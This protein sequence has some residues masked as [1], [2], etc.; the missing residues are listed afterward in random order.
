MRLE[1][2]VERLNGE[3]AGIAKLE[4]VRWERAFYK[5]TDTFQAQIPEAAQCD[6]VVAIFRHRL[7]TELPSG[8]PPMP[9]GE[10]YPSGTAYEILTALEVS[11]REGLPDVYVFRYPEPPTVTLDAE[12]ANALVTTQWE[13]LKAFFATWFLSASG[14]FTAA[15]HD[16]RSTDQF[17]TQIEALLR[18]WLEDKILE[19][20]AVVWPIATKG[21]PFRG[22]AAFAA[23]HAPVFFGRGRDTTKAVDA[24]KDAANRDTPFLLV[25]GPSGSG[26]S[27][28]ALAGISP[29]LTTPGVVPTV[30]IW[31]VATMRPGEAPGDPVRALAERLF[32]G[33][34]DI[35]EAEIGRPIALPEL[36]LSDFETP[37][38]LAGLLSHA[39]DTSV[40]PIVSA[41][42]RV[43]QEER[44]SGGYDRPLRADLL[45]VV[46][47][48][49]D[50]FAGDLPEDARRSFIDIL[51]RLVATGRVWVV[52]TLRANLYEDYL[53]LPE[54]LALKSSGAAY[55]LTPPGPA[56]LADI[57]HEPATAAGLV[58]ESDPETG[59]RLDERLLREADRPDMLPLLQFALAQLFDLRDP[60]DGETRLTYAAYESIGGIDGAIDQ[61]AENALRPLGKE[62]KDAL[63]KLLRMLVQQ[64]QGNVAVGPGGDSYRSVSLA[65]LE[66]APSVKHLAD[67]LVTARI[68]VLS[69]EASGGAVRVVHQRVLQSWQRAREAVQ[70]NADF[71][72]VRSDLRAQLGRWTESGGHTSTLVA[73]G[74][75]L[76]EARDLVRRFGDELKPDLVHFTNASRWRQLFFTINI[77]ALPLVVALVIVEIF[78]ELIKLETDGAIR[79]MGLFTLAV[80][81]PVSA[82]I[83]LF[84]FRRHLARLIA[85]LALTGGLVG[86]K[87]SSRYFRERLNLVTANTL[88][89]SALAI[90]LALAVL[91]QDRFEDYL[92]GSLETL[93]TLVGALFFIV[94]LSWFFFAGLI[95][96]R[97]HWATK[98]GPDSSPL[99]TP[100]Q[101]YSPMLVLGGLA[102]PAAYSSSILRPEYGGQSDWWDFM[103]EPV[104]YA[105]ALGFALVVAF[106]EVR[107]GKRS[108][109]TVLQILPGIVL[110]WLAA[111][112]VALNINGTTHLFV[113]GIVAGG[114]GAGLSAFVVPTLRKQRRW[115]V[116]TGIGAC[117]GMLLLLIMNLDLVLYLA[118]QVSF[119]A[120]LGY[121]LGKSAVATPPAV[122]VT[123]SVGK[124][125]A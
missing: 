125:T 61:A 14:E 43:G 98:A 68:L 64:E 80:A 90:V 21:S 8:F 58:Y 40:R 44:D 57:V 10:P 15:F 82:S 5:A 95:R 91:A 102:V 86:A 111:Y 19:G 42:E 97:V 7:G 76:K 32:D 45:L 49:D 96:L 123:V 37:A 84:M 59:Q 30:D 34:D 2:V 77:R 22:L 99:S 121:C 81:W 51:S 11:R 109:R 39:D 62:A 24:L 117:A 106:G 1:Q 18:G 83:T 113:T 6:I 88:F 55:D 52:A 17:E 54:L 92:L 119:A 16:F 56:A 23:K 101:N 9:D 35:G 100:P 66:R 29:R 69:N 94:L 38:A 93:K 103:F 72:R 33:P 118:W 124:E 36:T 4:T 47:Q 27:S 50:L 107:W 78:L 115:A 104:L 73:R 25:V 31:R 108:I 89:L 110:A 112:G 75:P 53:K 67:A 116:A 71:Y 114:L 105:T 87:F 20:R 48:L 74:R 46:D 122:P 85:D 3:L 60:G 65:D 120:Y 63:P 13:R 79:I 70:A 41:L 12:D 28:L 26:K